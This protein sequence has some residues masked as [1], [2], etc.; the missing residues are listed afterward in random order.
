MQLN[1]TI[2]LNGPSGEELLAQI[3]PDGRVLV[4]TSADTLDLTAADFRAWC[5][6]VLKGLADAS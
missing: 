5:E 2:S 3:M 1:N 6:A 4:E